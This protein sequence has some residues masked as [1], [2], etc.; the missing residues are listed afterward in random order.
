[1]KYNNFL[2]MGAAGALFLTGCETPYGTPNRAG[3]GALIGGGA[4]AATGALVA[5]GHDAPVGALIGGGLGALAGGLI[6]HS[7][8][9]ENRQRLQTQAPMTYE[10]IDQGQPL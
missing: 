2:L 3:T 10:R 1:M 7:M 5:G 8:D 4:G 9:L 6:G